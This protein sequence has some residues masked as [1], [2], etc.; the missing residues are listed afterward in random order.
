MTSLTAT[1]APPSRPAPGF[2][3]GARA[4][5]RGAKMILVN[6]HMWPAAAA[7][8]F[9]AL[10]ACVLGAWGGIRLFD[11]M[12]AGSFQGWEGWFWGS[13]RSAA[14]YLAYFVI[15]LIAALLS[16]LIVLKLVAGPFSEMLSEQVEAAVTGRPAPDFHLRDFLRNLGPIIARSL[17]TVVY[18]IGIAILAFALGFIP[19]VGW[20]IAIAFASHLEAFG[21]IDITLGRKRRTL[22]EKRAWI[23]SH[24]PAYYGFGLA[25]FIVNLIPLGIIFVVPAAAAGGTL[26]VVED[27]E[28]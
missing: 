1:N 11:S 9:I 26:L 7:P 12:V 19:V 18:T 3:D 14:I 28:P 8:V 24:R 16:K 21:A 15:V 22:G 2:G 20:A 5:A 23:A 4:L 10:V 25:I 13:L 27:P 6:P 17:A